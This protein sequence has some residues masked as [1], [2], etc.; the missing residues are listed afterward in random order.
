MMTQQAHAR[1]SIV[2]HHMEPPLNVVIIRMACPPAPD[3]TVS[4]GLEA[5]NWYSAPKAT[6]RGVA[7][8]VNS[9]PID[10]P[11][12]GGFVTMNPPIFSVGSR[13]K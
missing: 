11:P 12:A 6:V 5:V 1:V 3:G 4:S 10:P 13:V 7:A 8:C 2:N 9:R